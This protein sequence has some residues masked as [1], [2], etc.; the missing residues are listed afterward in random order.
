[1]N[2]A[3]MAQSLLDLLDVA[4]DDLAMDVQ[5]MRAVWRALAVA[6]LAGADAKQVQFTRFLGQRAVALRK[7]GALELSR[8]VSEMIDASATLPRDP[9]GGRR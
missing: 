6:R 9:E 3:D 5:A 1:M 2:R 8:M 4:D 7:R